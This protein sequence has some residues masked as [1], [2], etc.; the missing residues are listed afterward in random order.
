MRPAVLDPLFSPVASLPGV[1]PK[2]ADLIARVTGREDADDCRVLDLL[3]HAPSS[4]IDRRNR[5]GIALA[6]QG[7]IVTIEG[8]VDRHPPPPRSEER[9]V[10]KKCVSPCRARWA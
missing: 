5:P 8:R 6:P 3:F 10:G 7:A 1:G 9:R 2:L 4:I